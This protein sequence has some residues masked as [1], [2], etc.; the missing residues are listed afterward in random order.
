MLALYRQP[1]VIN[2]FLTGA[3]VAVAVISPFQVRKVRMELAGG[4]SEQHELAAMLSSL[5]INGAVL[6]QCRQL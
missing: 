4:L 3:L 1:I 2:F 6:L 5:Q